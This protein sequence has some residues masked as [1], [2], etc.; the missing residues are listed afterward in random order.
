MQRL[1]QVAKLES[2][3]KKLIK[4]GSH[5]QEPHHWKLAL[6]LNGGDLLITKQAAD[7][8]QSPKGMQLVTKVRTIFM[9]QTTAAHRIVASQ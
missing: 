5:F 4:D 8:N 9:G 3:Y 1:F 2:L 6:F 7:M